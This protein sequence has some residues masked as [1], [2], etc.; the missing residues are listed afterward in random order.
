MFRKTGRTV[1]VVGALSAFAGCLATLGALR[2]VGLLQPHAPPDRVS[3]V[4]E[5]GGSVM[6]FALD[7]TLHI[8][9]MT[10]S[11]GIQDVVAKDS[12]DHAQI[13]LIRRHLMHEAELFRS[14]NFSDPASIHGNAMPGLEA[15]SAGADRIR[16]VYTPLPTGGR[17]TYGTR[18]PELITAVHRWFGAQLS[19]HGADATYR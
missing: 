18:D 10:D 6:P 15:L 14:G 4:H 3:M 13:A 9:E 1:W 7:S 12:T 5:M 17:I 11:G 16:I 8:F 2:A 19:D